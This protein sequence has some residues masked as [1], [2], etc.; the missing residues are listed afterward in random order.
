MDPRFRGMTEGAGRTEGSGKDESEPRRRSL[1]WRAPLPTA[2]CRLS[3]GLE[4]EHLA[5]PEVAHVELAPGILTEAGD[6]VDRPA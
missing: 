5:V 1:G 6:V 3:S 4:L 2:Y